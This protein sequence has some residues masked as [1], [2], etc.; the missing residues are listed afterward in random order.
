MSVHLIFNYK[1][2]NKLIKSNIMARGRNIAVGIDVGTHQIKVLVSE[3]EPMDLQ[4]ERESPFTLPK[5]IASA[6]IETKGVRHGYV[7]NVEELSKC[8]RTVV[9]SAEKNSGLPIK[10]AYVSIGGVGL[11]AI[12]SIGSVVT[13][14]ADSEI[15]DLDVR[16]AIEES[17]KELPNT[18]ILN[19]KII[20]TIPL[21]Y[22]VDGR[23]VLGRPQGLKG[24]KLEAR[25]L[26]ITCL[27]HHLTDLLSAFDDADV[28][29]KDVIASP[30][31][32]SLISLTKTQKIAG[33]V[34]LNIG[35]ETSSIIVY[36]NN[37]PVSMEVFAVGS[38]DIT[39]DIALG[40]KVSIEEADLIKM[41]VS[42][43]GSSSANN[44]IP[45]FSKK[46]L[47]EI[48][49]ARLSDIFD[50]IE[51]H[52]KKIDRNGLLP[53]G[54]IL[55]GGGS[56]LMNI[57]ELAREAL[58][59]PSKRHTLKLEGN[60]KGIA[61]E[62]EWSVAYGLTVLAFS[63]PD[64]RSGP[65]GLGDLGLKSFFKKIKRVLGGWIKQFLP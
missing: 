19:R 13:T 52:L 49:I 7:T 2:T 25:V 63:S 28:E 4:S 31:A 32:A 53:A 8:I 48:I 45:N 40:L 60:L 42:G 55:T 54:I 65:G 17:E 23:K 37:I 58:R 57:E 12:V 64:D 26:Y 38:N 61:R 22:K 18:Y 56:G 51:G 47:D 59:L 24:V 3:Q 43:N 44:S 34:L 46:K 35:S 27:A 10:K 5:I 41:S 50:L 9:N 1:K 11:G 15:T 62:F 16:R 33:C 30:I 39:N 36:E 14:K 6:T 21:E 29:I 20:H